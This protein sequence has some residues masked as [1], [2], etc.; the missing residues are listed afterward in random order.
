MCTVT[1]FPNTSGYILTHNRDE[2]PSRS[3][4]HISVEKTGG[5]TLIYPRDTKAG[6][7]WVAASNSGLT[8]CLLNGAFVKHHHNPPY[9]RSRGLLLLDFFEWERPDDFFQHYDLDGIEPFTFLFFQK[10]IITELRWDGSQRH[11]KNLPPDRAHF[12]CSATLY[13]PEM[14]AKREQVFREWLAKTHT[15]MPSALYRL[16]LTGSVGDPENDYVMN[17]GGRVRTVSLTQVVARQNFSE[18]RYFDLL[19]GLQDKRRLM[20]NKR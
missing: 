16:H 4:Q 17:R 1:F 7:A 9:R 20:T 15:P 8:A 12:W 2:A 14:Q 3:P 6:G 10:N 5:R 11:L 18:M 19:D 13:P